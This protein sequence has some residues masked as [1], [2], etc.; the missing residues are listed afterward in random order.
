M[1]E[2][3]RYVFPGNAGREF[4]GREAVEK[5]YRETLKLAGR[6]SPHGWR[7]ALSTIAKDSGW[8]GDVVELTLDHVHDTAVV[9]AYDRGERR[10]ER[11]K[12]A[13]WWD[14][15]LNPPSPDIVPI[16]SA[17]SA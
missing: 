17:R 1:P 11:I 14:A 5:V 13:A 7:S 8:A 16:S 4:V 2:K 15:Q 9:R 12:L 10:T 3:A 6:M